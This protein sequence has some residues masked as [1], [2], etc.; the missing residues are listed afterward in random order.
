MI[1]GFYA[2][3]AAERA[4]LSA[5]ANMR[6]TIMARAIAKAAG[7]QV[8]MIAGAWDGVAEQS[9]QLVGPSAA[10][11][12]KLLARLFDQDSWLVV[13]QGVATLYGREGTTIA[14]LTR[15]EPAGPDAANYSVIDGKRII[16]AA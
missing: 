7:C 2:I 8:T 5:D 4:S 6:R 16:F 1:E 3:V 10:G 12:A 13:A 11:T 15:A 9:M 14:V